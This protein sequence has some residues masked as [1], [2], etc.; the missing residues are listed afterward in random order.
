MRWLIVGG[1]GMLGRDAVQM[2]RSAGFSVSAPSHADLD[3]TDPAACQEACASADV[4][5]NCAGW[6]AVDA[7]EDAEGCAFS[8][9]ALAAGYLSRAAARVGARMVQVSTDYVF[10]G[11]ANEPY[12]EDAPLS[13]CSAYGRSKAAGE[14]AVRA[15]CRDHLIVRT[16]WLFGEHG[17][18]FPRTIARAAAAGKNL[19]VVGDQRGQPTWTVDVVA[20]VLRL[21][22]HP[23][24]AGTYHATASGSTTWFDFAREVVAAAGRDPDVVTAVETA[25]YPLHA[26]RPA[27]SVLGHGALERLGIADIGDWRERWRLAAERVLG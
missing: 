23:A 2:L 21:V 11:R 25:D 5:L 3:I 10:D 15:E 16:A 8:A 12:A 20:L 1:S 19:R 27:Y 13:P 24:P 7:A 22:Q 26:A 17:R 9:N 18:C 6:T 4:V 14:W